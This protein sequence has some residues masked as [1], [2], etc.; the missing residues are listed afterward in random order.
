MGIILAI[1][2]APLII[3]LTFALAGAIM[4]FTYG[5]YLAIK[6]E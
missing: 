6:G 2:F 3:K 4:G 1:I 5:L